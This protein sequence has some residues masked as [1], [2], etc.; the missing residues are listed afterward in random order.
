MPILYTYG[1]GSNYQST[2]FS[3]VQELLNGILD[4]NTNLIYAEDIRDAVYSLWEKISEV[5]IIANSASVASPYFYNPNPTT[6]TN[7]SGIPKGTTFSTPQTV[8]D[9]FNALL[10]PYNPPILSLSGPG[11]VITDREFGAQ[12]TVQ[13]SWSVT[14]TSNSISSIYVVDQF[15]PPNTTNGT[16]L[17]TGYFN[18]DSI[19]TRNTFT[20]SVND[21]KT[22]TSINTSFEWMNKIYW[23]SVEIPSKPNFTIASDRNESQELIN[24][25]LSEAPFGT[26]INRTILGLTGAGSGS[27]SALSKTKDRT[28][29]NIDG[30]GR[31]LIFAWPSNLPN[32]L[33][34]TFLIGANI[35]S[36]F[37]KLKTK[38]DLINSYNIVTAYEVW[39][40]N[41]AYN[42]PINLII[43]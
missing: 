42:S 38:L 43:K 2:R 12:Q 13:L 4:N 19:Y 17:T 8:Q 7:F 31:Y 36:A 1:T 30:R 9:M 41:T 23:G 35:S 28:Y 37:T 27:G 3:T 40:S 24:S 18:S 34:P 14:K 16:K 21:G 5:E 26:D 32:A 22:T 33:E 20:M 25:V 39:V 11:G 6:A 10:Y 29:D 15:F